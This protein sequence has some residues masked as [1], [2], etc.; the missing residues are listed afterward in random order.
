MKGFISHSV[1]SR[2]KIATETDPY[3]AVQERSSHGAAVVIAFGIKM[4]SMLGGDWL[5]EDTHAVEVCLSLYVQ[6]GTLNY[7]IQQN[8]VIN[9]LRE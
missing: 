9:A 3:T 1:A 5:V 7:L 2:Q 4:S 6:K 8:S